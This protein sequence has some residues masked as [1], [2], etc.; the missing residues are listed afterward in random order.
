MPLLLVAVVLWLS[1]GFV[2]VSWP[3]RRFVLQGGGELTGEEQVQV[4]PLGLTGGAACSLQWWD[5][6]CD[7]SQLTPWN[8]ALDLG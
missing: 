4:L 5:T 7:H 3:L 1:D 6:P 2:K 8:S